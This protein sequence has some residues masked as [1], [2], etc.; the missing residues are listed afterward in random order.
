MEENKVI[1]YK[2]SSLRLQMLVTYTIE[3]KKQPIFGGIIF[4]LL[5]KITY[6]IEF[7]TLNF[8]YS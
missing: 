7:K 5:N 3:K 2:H 8:Q 1:F 4:L 6:V